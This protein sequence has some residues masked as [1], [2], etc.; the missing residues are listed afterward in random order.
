[1][2]VIAWDF[3]LST[4]NGIIVSTN[5]RYWDNSNE[6]VEI[7]RIVTMSRQGIISDKSYNEGGEV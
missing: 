3:I 4:S 1:M 6:R 2:C 7:D 5:L